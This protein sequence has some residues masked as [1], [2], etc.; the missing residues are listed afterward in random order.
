MI[1]IV[2]RVAEKVSLRFLCQSGKNE[3][4]ERSIPI[5]AMTV[6]FCTLEHQS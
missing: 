4:I 1:K 3:E 5:E 2:Q 6:Q